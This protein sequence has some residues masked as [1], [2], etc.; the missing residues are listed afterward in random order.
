MRGRK[1]ELRL[2]AV[3]LAQAILLLLATAACARLATPEGWSAAAVATDVEYRGVT[4]EEV[5]YV[6]TRE[7]QIL[8][9]DGSSGD[10]LWAFELRGEEDRRA[11]YGTPA[12]HEGALYVGGYDGV[13]YVLTTGGQDL[14]E[15][16][17]GG[18]DSIVGSPVI[19][20]DMV[21]VGS[22]DGH[23]YAYDIDREGSDVTLVERWKVP[24]GGKVWSTPAVANGVVYFGSLDRKLYAVNLSD[25]TRVWTEPFEARGAMVARPVVDG[26]LVY[27]GAFDSVFYAVD[28]ATGGEAARFDG[29]SGWFWAGALVSGG[30]VF[31]P[32]LDGSLYA[33]AG[34]GLNPVWSEPLR[35]GGPIVGSPAIVGDRIAVPSL[36]NKVATVHSVR[37]VDGG[38]SERCS[39]GSRNSTLIKASLTHHGSAVYVAATDRS[40]RKLELDARGDPHEDWVR[41][42]DQDLPASA[43]PGWVRKC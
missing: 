13:L 12:L 15:L 38:A 24:T 42:T 14:D 19:A 37:L 30:V 1:S 28:A 29:A 8:A 10:T 35:T 25:G 6:G 21:L 26:G 3:L 40:V 33:L 5:V 36:E 2:R 39:F 16:E 22:S 20:D 23:L 11:I 18:G 17:V 34:D 4:Y 9:L 31:A 32:S 7:G 27:I 43:E 41:F